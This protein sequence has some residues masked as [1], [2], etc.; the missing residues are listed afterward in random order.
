MLVILDA[1]KHLNVDDALLEGGDLPDARV[2]WMR[3]GNI[4]VHAVLVVVGGHLDALLVFDL[5]EHLGVGDAA[6]EFGDLLDALVAP[7]PTPSGWS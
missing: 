7:R 4:G 3:S 5:L 2:V 6:L 1:L